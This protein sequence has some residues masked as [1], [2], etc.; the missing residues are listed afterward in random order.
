RLGESCGPGVPEGMWFDEPQPCAPA[1]AL[2][3][4]TGTVG[5]EGISYFRVFWHCRGSAHQG[6]RPGSDGQRPPRVSSDIAIRAG[7]EWNPNARR[8]I[9]RT[10]VLSDS[11]RPLLTPCWSVAS[12]SAR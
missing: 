9:N 3:H 4:L 7:A 8:A 5:A 10:L 12:M 2:D 11:T 6:C 1:G